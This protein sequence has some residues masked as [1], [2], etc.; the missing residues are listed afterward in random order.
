M[1]VTVLDLP[2]VS[3]VQGEGGMGTLHCPTCMGHYLSR[4]HGFMLVK[5]KKKSASVCMLVC[6]SWSCDSER[7][8]P[9]S[10]PP[11]R[12]PSSYLFHSSCL[13][14]PLL[15]LLKASRG[16]GTL[17]LA[18]PEVSLPKLWSRLSPPSP[19]GRR[20]RVGGAPGLVPRPKPWILPLPSTSPFPPTPPPSRIC[21][22]RGYLLLFPV[23]SFSF[24]P[25][26]SSLKL[27][28]SPHTFAC[29]GGEHHSREGG[30]TLRGGN[31]GGG[32]KKKALKKKKLK[33]ITKKQQKKKKSIKKNNQNATKKPPNKA[34]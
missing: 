9:P 22:G 4:C 24:S 2:L 15:S 27:T 16:E 17:G 18:H 21:R 14:L 26:P 10:L 28:S 6:S 20:P 19:G 1:R 11:S 7:R 29:C 13:L 8:G 25:L 31:R 12:D 32:K 3:G 23:S 33:K 30:H 5:E 34:S